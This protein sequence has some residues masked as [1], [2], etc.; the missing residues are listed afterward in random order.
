ME[1]KWGSLRTLVSIP[2]DLVVGGLTLN[3]RKVAR[4]FELK[5][6]RIALLNAELKAPGR[7]ISYLVQARDKFSNE[8]KR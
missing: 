7:E 5:E 4:I 2:L 8:Q 1:F 6:R 3:S